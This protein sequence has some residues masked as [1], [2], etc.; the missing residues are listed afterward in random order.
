MSSAD[1]PYCSTFLL[2][3]SSCSLFFSPF[4][5]VFSLRPHSPAEAAERRL[6]G[7]GPLAPHR[8]GR[9]GARR[10][11]GRRLRGVEG[12]EGLGALRSEGEGPTRVAQ[13]RWYGRGLKFSMVVDSHLTY[14]NNPRIKPIIK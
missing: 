3:F 1:L 2:V 12:A 11:R 5:R 6:V 9:R 4:F 8:R 10:R 13:W 14:V 7:G